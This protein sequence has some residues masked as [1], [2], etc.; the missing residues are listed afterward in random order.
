[1]SNVVMSLAAAAALGAGSA[2]TAPTAPPPQV[3]TLNE[4]RLEIAAPCEQVWKVLLDRSAWME[5][6]VGR[7]TLSGSFGEAGELSEVRTRIGDQESVRF[8]RVLLATEPSRLVIALMAPESH[9]T[10]FADYHLASTATGCDIALTLVMVA[11]M[12]T[13]SQVTEFS[14][15]IA[16]G[17]QTKIEGDM[18]RLKGVVEA[19]HRKVVE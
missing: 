6:L 3:T 13:A 16:Q 10:A 18:R 19:R 11:D 5:S 4:T 7:R 12:Q 14:A 9:A 17:S 8:E 1:M 2:P 15:Q